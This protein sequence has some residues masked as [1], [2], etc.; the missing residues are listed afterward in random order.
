MLLP[1]EAQT[2]WSR[3]FGGSGNDF[4][5]CLMVRGSSI[6]ILGTLASSGTNTSITLITTSADGSNPVS[7]NFGQESQFSASSFERTSDNG[8]IIIGTNKNLE[9]SASVALI[10]TNADGSL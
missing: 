9:N 4:G 10:K 1:S 6:H 5:K 7:A 3:T 8:F 2:E